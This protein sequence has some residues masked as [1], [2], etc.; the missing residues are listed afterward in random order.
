MAEIGR[1]QQWM[2]VQD[3]E[4]LVTFAADQLGWT[5]EQITVYCACYR[6]E[7]RDPKKHG[8]YRVKAVWAKKPE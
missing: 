5:K 1:L 2:F 4:G 8:Y 3:V 7:A 6:K